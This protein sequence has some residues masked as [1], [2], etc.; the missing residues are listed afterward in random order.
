VL[1]YILKHTLYSWGIDGMRLKSIASRD[2]CGFPFDP[3]FFPTRTFFPFWYS[4]CCAEEKR[5]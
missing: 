3:H 4:N 1:K 5:L 2:V